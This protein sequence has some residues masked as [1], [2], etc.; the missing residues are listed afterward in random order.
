MAPLHHQGSGAA[1][2]E[3]NHLRLGE[4]SVRRRRTG[5]VDQCGVGGGTEDELHLVAEPYGRTQRQLDRRRR[6]ERNHPAGGV[7]VLALQAQLDQ[8]IA[9]RGLAHVAPLSGHG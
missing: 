3:G 5:A 9:V 8:P 2:V 4:E 7:E 1:E 6:D